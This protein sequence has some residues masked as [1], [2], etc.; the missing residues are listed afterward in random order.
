MREEYD[1]AREYGVYPYRGHYGSQADALWTEVDREFAE[2]FPTGMP[3]RSWRQLN[4][5]QLLRK[6]R[7]KQ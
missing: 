1:I 2:V 3:L 5:S 6:R 7:L 4:Q